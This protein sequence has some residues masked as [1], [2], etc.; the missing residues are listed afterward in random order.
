MPSKKV[1]EIAGELPAGT[2]GK[3]LLVQLL[4]QDVVPAAAEAP[5]EVPA[6][7]DSGQQV[8]AAF[9]AMVMAAFDDESL[10]AKAT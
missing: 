3:S 2:W 5:V 6:E 9:R 4:E 7:A 1:K 8:K 10:D